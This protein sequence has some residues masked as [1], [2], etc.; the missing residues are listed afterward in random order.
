MMSNSLYQ[1]TNEFLEIVGQLEEM[2]LDQ[3]TFQ[4]TLDSL[5]VPIEQKVENIV[6]YMKS[7]E[8]LAEAKKVEAKRLSESAASDLKKVEFFKNY[9]ADN[10]KKAGINKLQAGVFSLGWRKGSEVV[11]VDESKI[12][13]YEFYSHLYTVQKPQF[14]GKTELKKLIKE[15]QEIPGVSL[16]R[17]PDSLVVK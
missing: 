1:I 3:E 11:Q 9:M 13:P 8:A 12:P 15:G 16:V 7:L 10:L 17:N 2:E 5:Q 14:L 4:D 6:K